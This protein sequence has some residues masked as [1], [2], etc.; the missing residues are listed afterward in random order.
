MEQELHDVQI[1]IKNASNSTDIGKV[2]ESTVAK[3][4]QEKKDVTGFAQKITNVD[5]KEIAGDLDVITNDEIIEVKRSLSVVKIDQ[6]DKYINTANPKYLNVKNKKVIL[7]IEQPVDM[8]NSTIQTIKNMGITVVN[9]L[10][11]LKGALK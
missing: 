4:V 6:C 7:Y 11:D 5:T 2:L 1:A 10:E 9:S 3:A 8:N